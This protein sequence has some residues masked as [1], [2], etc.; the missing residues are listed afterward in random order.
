MINIITKNKLII[1]LVIILFLLFVLSL[2]NSVFANPKVKSINPSSGTIDVP[3]KTTIEIIFEN[4]IKTSDIT[5]VFVPKTEFNQEMSLNTVKVKPKDFFKPGITYQIILKNKNKKD[6]FYSYFSTRS[7]QGDSEVSKE[8]AKTTKEFYPLAPFNPP[9]GSNFYFVYTNR[10]ALSVYFLKKSETA[11][12]EFYSW[13]KSKGVDPSK[14]Q[15]NF[16]S[17]P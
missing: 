17:P 3:P 5:V 1:S 6:F 16:V 13:A 8:A 15:I 4:K 7:P 10:L 2:I 9:D 12:E 11:K 14:H